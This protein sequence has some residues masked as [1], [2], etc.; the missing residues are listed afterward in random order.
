MRLD[1]P[2]LPPLSDEELDAEIRERFGAGGVLNIFRTFAHHPKLLKRWLVFGGHVLAKSSLPPRERELLILRTAW[3]CRAGYEWAHHVDIAREAGLSDAEIRRV[4][5]GPDAAGWSP[6][7]ETLLRA[8]DELHEQQFVGDG[9][10]RDLSQHCD[11]QQLL[12]AVFTV[13][14]YHLVSMALNTFGV[15]LEPGE[16]GAGG[17]PLPLWPEDAPRG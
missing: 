8:A 15:Q 10:W 6:R 16:E 1:H 4:P 17:T 13:G 11:A 5:A 3:L 7:E 12:D 9:T 2:R 14:Q